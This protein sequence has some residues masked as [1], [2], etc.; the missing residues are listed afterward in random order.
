MIAISIISTRDGILQR[1]YGVTHCEK[2]HS[3][4]SHKDLN[5]KPRFKQ[6]Q[7]FYSF[8]TSTQVHLTIQTQ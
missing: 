5:L 2:V 7:Q 4:D 8:F 3:Y 1:V 6:Q